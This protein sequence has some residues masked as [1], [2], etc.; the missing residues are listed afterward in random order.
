VAAVLTGGLI[1]RL[2]NYGWALA[3]IASAAITLVV[4][5]LRLE[6]FRQREH[7][8]AIDLI[9]DG[10]DRISLAVVQRQRQ[11]LASERTRQSLARSLED[12]LHEAAKPLPLRARLSAVPV[13]PTVVAA[14]AGEIVEVV[15]LLRLPGASTRGV[16][17]AERLV[18]HALSP[19]YGRDAD[20][21]REELR[22]VRHLLEN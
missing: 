13:D 19:L 8:R 1:A 10:H 6:A 16:A 11:R 14:A 17:R 7:D 3:L 12:T 21:L 4:L 18:E 9:L 20:A 22:G 5:T 15:C 2:E